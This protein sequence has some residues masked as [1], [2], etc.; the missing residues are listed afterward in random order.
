L[1]QEA[2]QN[3]SP[4]LDRG[5]VSIYTG[6][7][8]G[9]TTAAIGSVVRAVGHG[10]RAYVIFFVKGKDYIHGE[11]QALA[12]LPNVTTTSFG[13]RGWVLKNNIKPEH[14]EQAKQALD[15][16]R[17]AMLSGKYDLV[18]LDEINIAIAGKLVEV[19]DVI[20]LINDKPQ[21]V[22]LILTGRYADPRLV[23]I[24]DLVSEIL[25]IKHPYTEGVRARKGIE[26]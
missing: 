9:K 17:Q 13:Q 6:Q 25:M 7:G 1:S 10:L 3:S 11:L 14:K 22:E 24:A 26:Y 8:K 19:D 20:G 5:L 15:T 2:H 23:R 18:V 4:A 12:Q 21:N 16:A